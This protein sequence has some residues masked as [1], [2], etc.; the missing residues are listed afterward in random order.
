MQDTSQ[1]AS[2]GNEK[3]RFDPFTNAESGKHRNPKRYT[4]AVS[5]TARVKATHSPTNVETNMRIIAAVA[6]AIV[7]V[8]C[9]ALV[10]GGKGSNVAFV[11]PMVHWAMTW[12]VCTFLGVGGLVYAKIKG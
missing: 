7:S 1:G 12:N 11:I 5:I 6:V 9:L 8:W 2:R 3:E 4:E 10:I